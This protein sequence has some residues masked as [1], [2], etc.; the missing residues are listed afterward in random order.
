MKI[1]YYSE[2]VYPHAKKSYVNIYKR[3]IRELSLNN[4]KL[5]CFFFQQSKLEKWNCT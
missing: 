4:N 2:N 1:P 3:K 5:K